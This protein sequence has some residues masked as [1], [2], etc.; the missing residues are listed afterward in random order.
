MN[1][2]EDRLEGNL[3]AR[4]SEDNLG[5]MVGTTTR[6][7]MANITMRELSSG[8]ISA[9]GGLDMSFPFNAMEQSDPLLTACGVSLDAR[10]REGM[11]LVV[12]NG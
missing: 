1:R 7:L 8:H 5:N 2:Y 11:A 9:A 3:F 6:P 10:R 12:M 4:S